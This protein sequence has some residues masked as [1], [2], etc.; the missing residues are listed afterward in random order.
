MEKNNN[1][2]QFALIS[3]ALKSLGKMLVDV[4]EQIMVYNNDKKVETTKEV[5]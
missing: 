2:L 5:E 4:A 3:V 1:Q